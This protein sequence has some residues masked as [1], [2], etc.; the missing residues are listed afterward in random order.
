MPSIKL[1]LVLPSPPCLCLCICHFACVCVGHYHHLPF[2]QAFLNSPL[3]PLSVLP[4][5][6]RQLLKASD[7]NCLMFL[8]HL[9][10]NGEALE[11][12]GSALISSYWRRI[13]MVLFPPPQWQLLYSH[14][15]TVK[16]SKMTRRRRT[17]GPA[18][19]S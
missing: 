11:T 8:L 10:C 9:H 15:E 13:S 4:P 16:S 2:Y 1:F 3:S 14:R 17:I 7:G 19:A 6:Y 5:P 12:I 18:I